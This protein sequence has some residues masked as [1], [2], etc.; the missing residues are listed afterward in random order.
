MKRIFFLI[1]LSTFFN[2]L[3]YGS[4]F[5]RI[6]DEAGTPVLQGAIR[7]YQKNQNT[8]KLIAMQHFGEQEFY[9]KVNEVMENKTVIYELAGNTYEVQ[10]R[11]K[12]AIESL[13]EEYA[14]RY[15][16]MNTI[17][18]P[19]AQ[20]AMAYGLAEQEDALD[21]S[22][23][24]R[25]LHADVV[26]DTFVALM[27]DKAAFKNYI[28]NLIKDVVRPEI[29]KAH[30]NEDEA[31]K[32]E[33]NMNLAQGGSLLDATK[34]DLAQSVEEKDK[35]ASIFARNEFIKK[36]L[37]EL[38]SE[39]D[40]PKEVVIVYGYDHL[41]DIEKYLIE[42]GYILVKEEWIKIL[43]LTKKPVATKV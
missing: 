24:F 33:L 23:V 4:P 17:T 27:D 2:S 8:I 15:K 28:D 22:K 43:D 6:F 20:W 26:E 7:T 14:N 36:R 30:K 39:K 12:S 1:V 13:G 34:R 10:K 35:I 37:K 32:E 11:L 40:P 31:L 42:H 21:Y 38:W 16:M 25:L 41:P 29:F 3:I 5:I 18:K 9:D 19:Y